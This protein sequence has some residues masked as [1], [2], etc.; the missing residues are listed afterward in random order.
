MH[1]KKVKDLVVF[2][3]VI[4]GGG[5]GGNSITPTRTRIANGRILVGHPVLTVCTSAR[6]QRRTRPSRYNETPG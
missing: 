5:V 6:V 2:S 1:G 3:L 4:R